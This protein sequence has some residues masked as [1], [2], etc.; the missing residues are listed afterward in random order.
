[1]TKVSKLGFGCT[2]LSGVYNA[3]VPEEVGISIIKYAF[4]K[5]ITFFDTS[6]VYGLNAN[7]VLVGKALKELARDKIQLATK[8]GIIKIAPNGLEVKGTPE[9]VRSC[10]EASLKRL[11]VDNIDLY[12]QHR[13]DTTVP[14]EDTMGELKN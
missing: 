5:R 9:Y 10:C 6:D 4:N 12:Y 2:G 3:P 7:E 11:S 8:F 13:V 14:I 1:M